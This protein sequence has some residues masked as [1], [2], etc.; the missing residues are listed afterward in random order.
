[1]IPCRVVVCNLYPFIKTVSKEGVTVAE[2]VEQIDIGEFQQ[3]A[4]SYCV[5]TTFVDSKVLVSP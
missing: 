4:P 3:V 2:V 5:N 1:M